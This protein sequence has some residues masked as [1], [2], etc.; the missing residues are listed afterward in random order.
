MN[1]TS[2]PAVE[3]RGLTRRFGTVTAVDGIDL[4]IEPGSVTGIL[5]PN[6]SGKSTFLRILIGLVRPDAGTAEV[7]GVRLR[8]DGTAIRRVVTFSPGEIA[9]YGE[10]R[11][12]EQLAWL[13]RGRSRSAGARARA[14][15]LRLG[16][17]LE[18]RVHQFSHGMKRQLLFAAAMG[19]EVALRI[20]DEPTEGL[21]PA[22]RREVLKVIEEDCERGGT[23]L[24]SSHHLSEVEE[25]CERL[26][27]FHSGRILADEDPL[28]L[29]RRARR[30]LRLEYE[31][32]PDAAQMAEKLAGHQ[33]IARLE[34]EGSLLR[35]EL[36]EE[37]CRGFLAGLA[38]LGGP[39]PLVVEAGRLSL[40]DLYRTV[41]G[42][43]G[44]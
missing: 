43:S 8:G 4:V 26:V 16:L 44:L 27:F 31:R 2:T 21:D 29:T 23:V 34:R 42:V 15:A 14:L 3:A 39:P 38:N 41:Y 20:L 17:P 6:G 9:L 7:A 19:P 33:G 10:M 40:V 13:L 36:E 24:L 12:D 28:E 35:L 32:E 22:K 5:G 37:D 11:A 1:T 30:N 25:V 18:K